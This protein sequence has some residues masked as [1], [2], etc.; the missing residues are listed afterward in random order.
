MSKFTFPLKCFLSSVG[1]TGAFT[2]LMGLGIV[3]LDAGMAAVGNVFVEP[4]SIPLKPFFAFL[5]T[6]KMLGVA[7]LWGLGPMPRSIA[8]PGLLTAASCGAYG[9][10]AV[11]EGPYIA[12]A[13]IGM[14][15]A[16]YILEG[17][18]K[19]SKKE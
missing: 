17:K 13:Y 16:L 2:A 6:C 9:H 11:G 19:S 7:S 14:L 12:I 5:G 18:E 4:L 15:A 1:V 3:P 8:L 10:Y